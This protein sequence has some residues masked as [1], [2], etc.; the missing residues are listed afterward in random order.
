ML[1]NPFAANFAI[2]H[3]TAEVRHMAYDSEGVNMC[4]GVIVF[5]YP[6]FG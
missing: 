1:I 4:W 3:Y 5:H 2:D 6:I